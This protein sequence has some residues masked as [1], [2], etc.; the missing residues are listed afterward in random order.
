MLHS[1]DNKLT[2]EPAISSDKEP[3]K[4]LDVGKSIKVFDTG[5]LIKNGQDTEHNKNY[6]EKKGNLSTRE[7]TATNTV[8]MP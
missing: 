4:V 7:S 8:E 2:Q 5:F 3:I 1:S 6:N